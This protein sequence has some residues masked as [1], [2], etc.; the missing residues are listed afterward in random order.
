MH[1]LTDEESRD[2]FSTRPRESQLGAWAS[3]QS[4]V[5]KNR[6]ELEAKLQEVHERFAEPSVAIPK[7][8]Y[9]GGFVVVPLL[10]EFWQGRKA[11]LHDRCE[12]HRESPAAAWTLRR[13]S[14]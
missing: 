10:L 13:L 1:R 4:S 9:W 8:P 11:R 7:P 5:I 14:P 6:T 3:H 2:Y 12:Y